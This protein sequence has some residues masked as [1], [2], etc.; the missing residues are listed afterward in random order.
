MHFPH[1]V[2]GEVGDITFSE[3]ISTVEHKLV[4]VDG[5]VNGCCEGRRW[6]CSTGREFTG[7][8]KHWRRHPHEFLNGVVEVESDH[9][10]GI[11]ASLDL[12]LINEV[13]MGVLGELATFS[14]VKVDVV[15]VH[16]EAVKF[17]AG[18]NGVVGDSGVRTETDVELHFVVLKGNE[19]NGKAGVAA[20]PELHWD[21]RAPRS[22]AGVS[23][24][25]RAAMS[26]CHAI[27]TSGDFNEGIQW[28]GT[29][30]GAKAGT[31]NVALLTGGVVFGEVVPHGEPLAVLA[32]N[33]LTTDFKFKLVK[34]GM[35]NVGS[36]DH[37]GCIWETRDT[38]KE[39]TRTV[40]NP[41][42]LEEISVTGH[43]D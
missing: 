4:G 18:L 7:D 2:T 16:V 5:S 21:P 17:H 43:S 9:L 28:S 13:F 8:G 39:L 6:R 33:E 25:V 35:S 23:H 42:T 15:T 40:F 26:E 20:E 3:P 36:N 10:V 22:T 19:G 11:I 27:V 41:E 34:E 29:F 12:E 14:G 24:F 30:T 38:R 32:I 37:A 1:L 31:V